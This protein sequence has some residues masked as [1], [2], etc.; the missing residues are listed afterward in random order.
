MDYMSKKLGRPYLSRFLREH[1]LQ[2]FMLTL[3]QCRAIVDILSEAVTEALINGDE[4]NI[5]RL[6]KLKV[7]ERIPK[8][9]V[10][11]FKTGEFYTMDTP[12]RVVKFEPAHSLKQKL[13]ELIDEEED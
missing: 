9:P 12:V 1:K 4:V 11:D 6:G 3:D 13:K 7:V 8:R 2:R 5:M 10:R